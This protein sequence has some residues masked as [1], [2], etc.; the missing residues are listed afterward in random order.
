MVWRA[1]RVRPVELSEVLALLQERH[2]MQVLQRL[3][4]GPAG[5]QDLRRALAP[6]GSTTLTRRMRGL[7]EVGLVEREVLSAQPPRTVYR[8]TAAGYRLRDVMAELEAWA[9]TH[10][11]PGLPTA[12]PGGA[13]PEARDITYGLVQQRWVPQVLE[14]LQ[15]GPSGFNELQRAIGASN[16]AVLAERLA[17]LEEVGLLVRSVLSVQPPRNSYRLTPSGEAFGTVLAAMQRWV[18]SVA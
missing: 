13:V 8:L 4:E 18:G 11:V 14:R 3:L 7:E 9:L 17:H 16:A 6:I 15:E 2:T 12:V 5:Y 10:L 1:G